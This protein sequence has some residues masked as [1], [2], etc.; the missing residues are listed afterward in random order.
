MTNNLVQFAEMAE[1]F[2]VM[3][4]FESTVISV[5]RTLKNRKVTKRDPEGN[6]ITNSLDKATAKFRGDDSLT[7]QRLR[8]WMDMVLYNSKNPYRSRMGNFVAKVKLLMSIKGV[9]LNPFGQLNNLKMGNINNMAEAAGGTIYNKN[10]YKKAVKAFTVDYLPAFLS[11]KKDYILSRGKDKNGDYYSMPKSLTK[12][13]A[14]ANK[15]RMMRAMQSKDGIEGYEGKTMDILFMMQHGAE[16]SI[17]TKSGMAILNNRTLTNKVTGEKISIYDAHS[18]DQKTG[19]LY[20]DPSLY[21]ET[22]Q[23]RYDMTNLIYETNKRLHGNYAWEDRM[24]IQQNLI[25]ELV[26]QFHKW[27]YPYW[28][29]FWGKAYHD[30]NLGET[31][32]IFNSFYKLNKAVYDMTKLEGGFWKGITKKKTFTEAWATMSDYQKANMSRLLGYMAFYMLSLLMK[33]LWSLLADELADDDTG[34]DHPITTKLVNFMVYLDD[35]TMSEISVAINPTEIGQFIKNPVAIVGFVG[36]VWDALSESAHFIL[37]PYGEED[38]VFQRG[39]NKGEYKWR[40]E[41]GDVLPFFSTINK[42]DSFE[43]LKDFYIK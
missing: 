21:E 38:E 12:Y 23:D 29:R 15:Y 11:A 5:L 17:Q 39:V 14:L 10:D 41:W 42:W 43:E 6:Y 2:Q 33:H 13:D 1:N 22:D 35:R 30:E 9:G 8:K 19:E 37:P 34:E 20:L 36:D 18:F 40:K 26:A 7:E 25:G 4:A 24:V 27:V 32:G 3:S 31:E 16:F 28:R